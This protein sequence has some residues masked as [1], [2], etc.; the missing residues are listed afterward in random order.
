MRNVK[1]REYPTIFEFHNYLILEGARRGKGED[2]EAATEDPEPGE[3]NQGPRPKAG[4]EEPEQK[5][6][7]KKTG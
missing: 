1:M 4:T 2:E 3:R 6:P 5:R 7:D